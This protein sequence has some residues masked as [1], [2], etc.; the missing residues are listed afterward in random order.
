MLKNKLT[1]EKGMVVV[2]VVVE[3]FKVQLSASEQYMNDIHSLPTG[4]HEEI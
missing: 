2:V 1:S 3:G 4:P